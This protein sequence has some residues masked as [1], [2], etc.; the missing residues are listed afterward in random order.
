MEL[1]EIQ[2]VQEAVT[3]F[4]KALGEYQKDGSGANKKIVF[5][6]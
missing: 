1:Q 2:R 6:N 5:E 4:D 3:S